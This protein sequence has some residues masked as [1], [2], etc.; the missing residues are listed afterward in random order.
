MRL[1]VVIAYLGVIGLVP[2]ATAA[3]IVALIG[4]AMASLALHQLR[5]TTAETRDVN[6][7][8]REMVSTIASTVGPPDGQHDA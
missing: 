7:A 8:N 6:K 2:M 3:M 5:D 4:V 1:S